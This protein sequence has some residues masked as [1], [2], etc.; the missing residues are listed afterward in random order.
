MKLITNC[1]SCKKEIGIK[2][3]ASTR[4]ELGMEKGD[5]FNIN[6]LHC[7]NN[8]K[9]HINDVRAVSSHII[10]IGGVIISLL[11]TAALWK[12]VGL[13]GIISITIPLFI[14]Q[15]QNKAAHA[16]NVYRSRRG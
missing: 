11:V 8:A 6:C 12:I 16:F 4:P 7:G 15:Y 10:T 3:N 5:T 13:V 2:S 14:W 1:K 9:V